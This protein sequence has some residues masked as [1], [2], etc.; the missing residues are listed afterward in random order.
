MGEEK[1]RILFLITDLG[2]GGAERSITD[3][4]LEFK[5]INDIE[6]I[7]GSLLPN[8]DFRDAT[9][10]LNVVFLDYKSNSLFKKS[11]TPEY[12][13]LIEGFKPHIIHSNR[14]LAEFLTLEKLDPEIVYVCHGRDN[15]IQ[16]ANLSLRSF[17]SKRL[18]LNYFEKIQL[19]R[20]KYPKVTTWFVANSS[21]TETYF[22]NVLPKYLNSKITVIHNGVNYEKFHNPS[23][24]RIFINRKIK[25]LNVGS[26]QEKKNQLFLIDIAHELNRMDIDFEMNLLGEGALRKAV[27]ERVDREKLNHRIFFRGKSD[28]VEEWMKESDI[29]LHTAWYEPF[30]IV[31]LEAMASGLPVVTLDGKGN[32]DL[33]IDNHNGFLIES[34]DPTVFAKR[35]HKLIHDPDFYSSISLNAKVFSKK[36]NM[37]EKAEEYLKFYKKILKEKEL[38]E[39]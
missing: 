21:H 22:R 10:E 17:F 39:G 2:K 6:C 18:L 1:I 38:I 28:R 37:R 31:F 4:C 13:K 5:K 25:I 26:F 12:H 20:R 11:Y 33:I 24:R 16:L 36:F 15:M 7:I 23:N 19:V 14:F 9:E 30:G 35:I 32:R 29:Y 27:E 34:Q 8:N 3:L